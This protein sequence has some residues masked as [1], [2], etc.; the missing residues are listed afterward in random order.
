MTPL[1]LAVKVKAED[2]MVEYLIEKAG[3]DVNLQAAKGKISK[4]R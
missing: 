2:K 1:M 3:A 4:Q